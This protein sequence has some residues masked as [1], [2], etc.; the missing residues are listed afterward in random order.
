MLRPTLCTLLAAGSTLAADPEW[1]RVPNAQRASAQCTDWVLA[2]RTR[3]QGRTS[4]ERWPVI[5]DSYHS[6]ELVRLCAE[7]FISVTK[8]C[9]RH[10][11]NA[12]DGKHVVTFSMDCFN[13]GVTRLNDE[14]LHPVLAQLV[15]V[16]V[17]GEAK[18]A[19]R[20]AK[21]SPDDPVLEARAFKLKMTERELEERRQNAPWLAA[22]RRLGTSIE[23]GAM[24]QAAATER[25][26]RIQAAAVE[27]GATVQAQAT[28]DLAAATRN[29]GMQTADAI[30][31][32]GDH[33]TY[34]MS[35]RDGLG[36][37]NTVCRPGY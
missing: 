16:L 12:T 31:Q 24:A 9:P 34:C 19:E 6:E 14:I 13:E 2:H 18:I 25:G 37:V 26:A 1:V 21:E 11:E 32:A 15:P 27:R 10:V 4:P 20:R 28:A 22:L 35:S 30:R 17:H 36:N 23:R 7:R 5:D 29:A 3:I 33:S 8:D